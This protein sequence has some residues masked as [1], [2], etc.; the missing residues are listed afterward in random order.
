MMRTN[1]GFPHPLP[2]GLSHF[3]HGQPLN[4]IGIELLHCAHGEETTTSHGAMWDTFAS[5]A[6]DVGFHVAHK[7]THIIMP[8]TF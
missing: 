7:Q 5:I 8:P 4:P 2:L 3:I 1:L 6:I